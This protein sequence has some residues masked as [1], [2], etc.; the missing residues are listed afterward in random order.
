MGYGFGY[1]IPAMLNA[2]GWLCLILCIAG[3]MVLEESASKII[4]SKFTQEKAVRKLLMFAAFVVI[5][6]I[7]ELISTKCLGESQIEGLKQES[8]L[9]QLFNENQY[10]LQSRSIV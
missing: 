10:Q 3:G 4:Y 8:R 7:G 9:C 5:F 2:P 1:S 6:L